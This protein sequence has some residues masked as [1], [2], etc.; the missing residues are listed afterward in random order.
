ML[1]LHFHTTG[2][3]LHTHMSPATHTH[4]PPPP[5]AFDKGSLAAYKPYVAPLLDAIRTTPQLV[6]AII[7]VP[8]LIAVGML[9][10]CGS[11]RV[12][13]GWSFPRICGWEG[14]IGVTSA[15]RVRAA[16]VVLVICA[17]GKG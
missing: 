1:V 4:M 3:C 12:G 2:A 9:L 8:V 17:R 7:V 11:K 5:Q 14:W 6:Y 13:E 15:S 10:F 16:I